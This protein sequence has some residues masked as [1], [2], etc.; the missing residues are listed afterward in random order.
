[1]KKVYI[2]VILL[3]GVGATIYYFFG[4]EESENVITIRPEYGEFYSVVA[5]TGELRAKNSIDIRGPA[6]ARMLGIWEMTISNLI[7][8]GS[9]VKEGDFV[10]ELNK[11]EVQSKINDINLTI[12]KTETEYEQAQLDSTLTL[13]N[14]RD[15]LENLKFSMEEKKLTMEQSKYEAPS[16]K[17]QAAIDYEKTVRSYEQSKKNYETKV[18]QAIAKLSQIE[19]DLL[20]E[21]QNLQKHL[22]ILEDFTIEAPANGMVIYAKDWNGRKKVVGSQ[23]SAWNPTVANLP[24]LSV[25]ES[26]TYVNEIDIQKIKENLPVKI[27]LDANPD[28]KLSGKVVSVAN[29]GETRSGTD[30]K[31]FEVIIKVNE[32]DT[33]LLPSMTTSNEI[34]VSSYD[35]VMSIPL[36][37]MHTEELNELQKVNYVYFKQGASFIRKQIEIGEINNDKAIVERGL[38]LDDEILLSEPNPDEEYEFVYFDDFEI[39]TEDE[40][41]AIQDSIKQARQ[42]LFDDTIKKDAKLDPSDFSKRGRNF[43]LQ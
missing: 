18:K 42:K 35:S 8:E 29:I 26:V 43:K 13:S 32:K 10:A 28:K 11:S 1:M 19:T 15:E 23:V 3:L 21:K 25:M 36:E 34:I 12:Q 5:V 20:K 40:V 39:K 27:S 2:V 33:T 22:D 38:E 14:A 9:Q 41:K 37:A 31:V 30:S 7:E 17:R 16:I 6:N 4:I 24:D